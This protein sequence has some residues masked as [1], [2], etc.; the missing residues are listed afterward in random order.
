M[1]KSMTSLELE[2]ILASRIDHP[3]LLYQDFYPQYFLLINLLV[4]S[5]VNNGNRYILDWFSIYFI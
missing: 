5:M 4:D 3:V 1:T 2:D